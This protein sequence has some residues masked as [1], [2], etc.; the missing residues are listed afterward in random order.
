MHVKQLRVIVSLNRTEM[1]QVGVE[2]FWA[3][4]FLVTDKDHFQGS[5]GAEETIVDALALPL[6]TDPIKSAV[7]VELTAALWRVDS[8]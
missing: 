7:R 5:G 4:V 2:L 6:M 8:R 1:V 3:I